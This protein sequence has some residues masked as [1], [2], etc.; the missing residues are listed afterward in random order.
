MYFKNLDARWAKK[1][2][3]SY[4]G[5]KNGIC[6]D[7]QHRI[8]RRYEVAPA[9]VHNSQLLPSLLNPENS[10]DI[11]WGDSAYAGRKFDE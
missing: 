9:N 5:Y 2:G 3:K 8:N 10:G 6:V 7:V 4:F 11:V 1:N